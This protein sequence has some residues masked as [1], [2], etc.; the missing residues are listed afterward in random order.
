MVCFSLAAMAQGVTTARIVGRVT[1]TTGQDLPSATVLAVHNPSGTQYGAATRADGRFAIL[2]MR[3][4]GPYTITISMVGYETQIFNDIYLSLGQEYPLNV[5]M[6]EESTQLEGITIVS[7]VDR[8][9]DDQKTGANTFVSGEALNTQPTLSRS[10]TDIIR[11]SPQSNGR[12]FIGADDRFNN[13]TID[14]SIF[15]NSFGLSGLPGGQTN[16][17]PISLDAIQEIQV[18]MAPYDVRQSG[19]TGAGINAITRSG[20][21]RIEGSAFFNTRNEGFVG[22]KAEGNDV[23]TA[24][25]RVDQYG[26]RLGGPI[27]KNKLFFFINGEAERV[28]EPATNFVAARPG[29]TGANVSRVRAS[30]LDS[31]SQFLKTKYGYDPGPYENYDLRTYSNKFLARLDYNISQKSKF[32]IRYNYLRSYRDVPASNS[33][34][35]NG[36]RDNGF[37][38]NFANSNYIINNDIHS[39]I[40]EHNTSFA[41]KFSNNI[42]T[43]YTANRDYRSSGGGIFPLVDILEGGRNLTTFGYEPFTPNNRLNTD[44]WQFQDNLTAYFGRHTLTAGFNLERFAF[45]NTFTPTYYGQ[46]VFNSL[47]D[48][49]TAA[50]QAPTDTISAVTLR[51]YVLTY[52]AL[53]GAAL[54]VARLRILYVGFYMQDEFQVNSKIKITAGIRGDIPFYADPEYSNPKFDT[55]AFGPEKKRYSTS[56]FPATSVLWAPRLGFNVD[57]LG[58]RSTVIRGG[59]GVFT[60]R[61]AFVW[62]SN[63]L[64]NN[65]VL[66]GQIFV[67]NTKNYVFSPDV[68]RHIPANPTTPATYNVATTDESFRFQQVWRSNLAIDQKLNFLKGTVA[69]LEFIYDRQINSPY[70][71]DANLIDPKGNFKGADQRPYFAYSTSGNR[72]VSYITDATIL[73]SKSGA[74]AYSLTAKLERNV[75]QGFSAMIAYTHGVAKDYITAGSIAASSFRDNF[76]VNSNNKPDLAWSNFDARHRLIASVRYRKEY[77]FGASA[78]NVFYEARNQGRVTYN[79]NNDMNGDG[80]PGNDL[81]YI[82]TNA[83]DTN[84]IV[85]V[86][87]NGFT[88]EQQAAAFEQFI[89]N[90][91]YLRSRRGQYAERNGAIMPWIARFDVSFIQ[92]FFVKVKENRN[93]LQL[94]FDIFNFGNLLNNR[95]GVGLQPV[96]GGSR[97]TTG[98]EANV[99]SPL[100]YEG[101]TSTGKPQY[102]FAPLT[103][104]TVDNKTINYLPTNAY[105]TSTRLEDVWR[106][107]IGIR[108]IF[109]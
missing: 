78:I 10:I 33:G 18:N 32:S 55:I 58:D 7:T 88:A 94:R 84:Q 49:Y 3:V 29:L 51:R 79:Y 22:N 14:G 93:T 24:R 31:L 36:R 91:E 80:N 12:S 67:D 16:S 107:Q 4:G 99:S 70:Y 76:S 50:N 77:K 53:P 60:G 56:K 109:N 47:N 108:Y 35:F 95:W 13:L 100:R 75:A 41:G 40:A 97:F 83:T 69:T 26:F 92:E 46:Y 2:G 96:Y 25:F 102:S 85:F 66:T 8:L 72:R 106:M 63:Q 59:T 81:L 19:F 43:G 21:N 68:K 87:K 57:V 101:R 44:T 48:F 38:L 71:Q 17:T 65:G 73:S 6:K 105:R 89:R 20:T 9:M 30:A 27:I 5:K 104:T 23:I 11:L 54:P 15:N 61:P 103:I 42:I 52:S 82:P 28:N 45:E 34:A 86:P 37:A 62:L 1:D 74:F 90:D 64:S 39:I 98:A